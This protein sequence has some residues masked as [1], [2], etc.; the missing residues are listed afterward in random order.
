MRQDNNFK[1]ALEL[2]N[3][4]SK[5]YSNGHFTFMAFTTNYRCYFDTIQAD[6]GKP[7]HQ[8]SDPIRNAI[9]NMPEGETPMQ[10]VANAF[11]E[12]CQER[13]INHGIY[14]AILRQYKD[15]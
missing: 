6:W 3:F 9:A 13:N 10:A 11:K 2:A 15:E 1:K 8:L 7:Q 4:I 5:K 12:L 14:M